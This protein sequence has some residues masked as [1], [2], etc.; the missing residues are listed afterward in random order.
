MCVDLAARGLELG[1]KQNLGYMF[2]IVAER[3]ADLASVNL[4]HSALGPP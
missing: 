1:F 2:L 3:Q 4:G